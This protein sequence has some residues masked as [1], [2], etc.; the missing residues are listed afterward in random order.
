VRFSGPC[1]RQDSDGFRGRAEASRNRLIVARAR[2][3]PMR[4]IESRNVHAGKHQPLDHF[5]GIT[6]GPRVHNNFSAAKFMVWSEPILPGRGKS[7]F[8]AYFGEA[9]S[10]T[11]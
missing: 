2:H 10:E 6:G 11:T 8:S 5:S 4:E 9:K 1:N 7:F 3:V